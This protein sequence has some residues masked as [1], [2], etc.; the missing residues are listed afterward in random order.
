MQSAHWTFGPLALSHG[1]HLAR[2]GC[3]ICHV[4]ELKGDL[5]RIVFFDKNLPPSSLYYK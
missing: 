5:D 4:W 2:A 3:S 1:D